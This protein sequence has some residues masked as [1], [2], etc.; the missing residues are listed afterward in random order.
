MRTAIATEPETKMCVSCGVVPV[1]KLGV[2]VACEDLEAVAA[3]A[4]VYLKR[5][6]PLTKNRCAGCRTL[7]DPETHE[8][9]Y[10]CD[11]SEAA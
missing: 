5:R 11:R 7:L 6:Q 3:I 1:G 2:C 9:R 8:C 4:V 10:H